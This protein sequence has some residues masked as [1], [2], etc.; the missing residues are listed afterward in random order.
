MSVI[1][2]KD[3][4]SVNNHILDEQHKKLIGFI[5]DLL[6]AIKNKKSEEVLDLVVKELSDY[7]F[8]H[9]S[10]EE[11][12]MKDNQ[13]SALDEHKEHHQDLINQLHEIINQIYGENRDSSFE[14]Y[15]LLN[16][17]LINHILAEDQKYKNYIENQS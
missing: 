12:F 9:F 10:F 7:T 4:Y 1:E 3:E 6:A 16:N 15:T 13:Y 14:L 11:D 8:Y 17:W 5:N 2:W